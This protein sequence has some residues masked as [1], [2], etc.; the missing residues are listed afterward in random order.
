MRG[1]WVVPEGKWPWSERKH[2][3]GELAVKLPYKALLEQFWAMFQEVNIDFAETGYG[4]KKER[5]REKM[6]TQKNTPID[7]E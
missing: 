6:R 3:S 1:L 4:K 2:E 5:E 7:N